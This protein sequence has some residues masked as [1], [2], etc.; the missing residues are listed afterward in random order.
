MQRGSKIYAKWKFQFYAL[1]FD[2]FHATRG[3]ELHV[4]GAHMF[5]TP[6]GIYNTHQR[7]SKNSSKRQH[8][9]NFSHR[10]VW[11]RKGGG[12][13]ERCAVSLTECVVTSNPTKLS[14][15]FE[16]CLRFKN[17]KCQLITA[18]PMHRA[19]DQRPE[20]PP[21]LPPLYMYICPICWP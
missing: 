9:L 21:P 20:T 4:H 12:A 1:A 10:S 19:L 18:S 7:T 5:W 11:Q 6:V 2:T 16:L 17:R 8:R 3:K 13:K 14:E 15:T